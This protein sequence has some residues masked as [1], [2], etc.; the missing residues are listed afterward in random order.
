MIDVVPSVMSS[1]IHCDDDD[2]D[3]SVA[4]T[5]TIFGRPFFIGPIVAVDVVVVVS[6]GDV[7]VVVL[8]VVGMMDVVVPS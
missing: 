7:V 3:D 2:D 4:N 5:C 8:V 6:L 1:V